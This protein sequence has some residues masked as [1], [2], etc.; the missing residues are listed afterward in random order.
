MGFYLKRLQTEQAEITA[1]GIKKNGGYCPC[2]AIKTE[3]TK[4][5]CKE[6]LNDNKS[7]VCECGLFEK[8]ITE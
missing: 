5:P 7:G 3:D 8:T 4:C 1:A 2:K 6:F